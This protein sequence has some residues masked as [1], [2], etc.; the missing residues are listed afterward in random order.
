MIRRL[1][2]SSLLLLGIGLPARAEYLTPRET[3]RA[4]GVAGT[5]SRALA[6][7][8]DS[9]IEKISGSYF[10]GRTGARNYKMI[11]PFLMPYE[12]E[13]LTDYK[14]LRQTRDATG[15][16]QLEVEYNVKVQE[17]TRQIDQLLDRV[18]ASKQQKRLMLLV[19]ESY[20]RAQPADSSLQPVLEQFLIERGYHLLDAES[21]SQARTR[22]EQII[23]ALAKED[24]KWRQ[25]ARAMGAD[26]VIRIGNKVEA[27]LKDQQVVNGKVVKPGYY[28]GQTLLD[29][30]VLDVS[31][32]RKRAVYQLQL[33]DSNPGRADVYRS[34]SRRGGQELSQLLN[35]AML[36]DLL[37]ESQPLPQPESRLRI[38]LSG[39][40]S[41]QSQARPFIHIL[42]TIK[43]IDS[44]EEVSFGEGMLELEV[45]H[46]LNRLDLE[47]TL[48]EQALS[49]SNLIRL[50]KNGSG[51]DVSNFIILPQPPAARPV[52]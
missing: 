22:Q 21:F 15:Q 27:Q 33:T 13:L 12:N 46:R 23:K 47:Q 30:E 8:R 32:G 39:I 28:D 11:L 17:L 19:E 44:V 49:N 50:D 20:D 51:R 45:K 25:M 16:L 43:G 42:Q 4:V 40:K 34:L 31:S 10:Q 41:Y 29:A 35:D 48:I 2:A 14:E 7:A 18:Q 36:Q 6:L 3:V 24:P 38:L 26:W 9:A 1:I 52:S 5:Y 37:E